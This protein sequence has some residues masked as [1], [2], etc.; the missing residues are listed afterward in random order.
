VDAFLPGVNASDVPVSGSE[1][2]RVGARFQHPNRF[3]R[4][5]EAG[6]ICIGALRCWHGF[7][8]KQAELCLTCCDESARRAARAGAHCR[9][10][11]GRQP[12]LTPQMGL[13]NRGET[14]P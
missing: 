2:K 5:W 8:Q 12:A 4:R 11:S 14:Y 6:I 13:K 1:E 10:H 9:L 7:T 3:M